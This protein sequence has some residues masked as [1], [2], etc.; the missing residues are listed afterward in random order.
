MALDGTNVSTSLDNC[1]KTVKE[2]S[3]L[4]GL[5]LNLDKSEVIVIETSARQKTQ[6]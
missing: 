5:S 3:A 1:F 2:W 4:N 6:A